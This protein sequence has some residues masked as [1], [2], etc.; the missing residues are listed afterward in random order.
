M[1]SNSMRTPTIACFPRTDNIIVS[2]ALSRSS[3]SF[4]HGPRHTVVAACNRRNFKFNLI[5][6][7]NDGEHHRC[8]KEMQDRLHK[9]CDSE[10]RPEGLEL[11]VRPCCTQDHCGGQDE[12]LLRVRVTAVAR[13]SRYSLTQRH[14][15]GHDKYCST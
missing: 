10:K 13:Q 6:T 11:L 14:S 4:V 7:M 1:N 2:Y 8:I 5:V 15:H 12:E 3:P 9:E